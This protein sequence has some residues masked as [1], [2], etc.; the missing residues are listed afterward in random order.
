MTDFVKSLYLNTR[1]FLLAGG[2]AALFVLAYMVPAVF[3]AAQVALVLVLL[4]WGLDMTLLYARQGEVL[5]S[6]HLPDKLSNGDENP[7]EIA[8]EN[9]FPFEV[10]V[11]VIE[12][13][14]EQFQL[15]N[16]VFGASLKAGARATYRYTL[17]PVE[18]GEYAFGDL[19]VYLTTFLGLARRRFVVAQATVLPCYPSFMQMRKYQLMAI[20]NRLTEIG[21]KKIRRLGHTTE[22][23]QI[24]EYVPGDD[25]RTVNW[26]ATARSNR[27]MVNQYVDERAQNVYCL[28][29]MSRAMKMPFEG[30]SLLDYAVNAALVLSNIAMYRQDKSGMITFAE[31]VYAH[32][33]ASRKATQ[34]NLI[35]EVL[36]KQETNFKESDYARLY[37]T[38]KHQIAQRS[39]LILFTNFESV[40][41]MRRQLPFFQRLTKSHLLVVIFF[42]NT[43]LRE[44]IHTPPTNTEEIYIKTI[45]E[46]FTFERRMIVKELE[47]HGISA[48]LTAPADLTVSA[49]NKY[50]ELKARGMI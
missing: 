19:N 48:I 26:K 50:L 15:R 27:L 37:A 34:M 28:I 42:E 21:V 44:L 7:V 49:V 32:L 1:L 16:L 38:V 25:Y 6:R 33:P 47:Q 13:A 14:P 8:V 5:A 20:S 43:E 11:Q 45:G 3:V 10:G 23:E 40:T 36:Y 2:V 30:M 31:R 29:D 12:E 41:A 22:F 46:H 4:L 17:R 39:L 18:R 24:K 9:R 35:M